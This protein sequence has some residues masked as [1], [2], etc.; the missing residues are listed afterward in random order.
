MQGIVFSYNLLY[1]LKSNEVSLLS[2][3]N[4]SANVTII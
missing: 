3:K 4:D 1:N 2:V